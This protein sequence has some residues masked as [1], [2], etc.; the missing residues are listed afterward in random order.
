MIF[1]NAVRYV[2]KMHIYVIQ[3]CLSLVLGRHPSRYPRYIGDFGLPWIDFI[4]DSIQKSLFFIVFVKYWLT[5]LLIFPGKYL[6]IWSDDEILHLCF[7]YSIARQ[8]PRQ[9]CNFC[10]FTMKLLAA[11]FTCFRQPFDSNWVSFLIE[12]KTKL[13]YYLV[14]DLNEK[15]SSSQF[16]G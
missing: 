13:V 11:L 6:L 9:S 8:G 16:G 3:E 5:W 7:K 2:K 1:Y 4:L 15:I 12:A 10:H 14:K